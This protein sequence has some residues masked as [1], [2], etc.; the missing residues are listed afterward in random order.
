[1]SAL[2]FD[3]PRCNMSLIYSN[4]HHPNSL[5]DPDSQDPDINFWGSCKYYNVIEMAQVFKD[6]GNQGLS[7]IHVNIRSLAKNLFKLEN[8]LSDINFTP[9]IIAV[10]ETKISVDVI[11]E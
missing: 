7:V 4:P 9:D 10:S 5:H 2:L 6:H 1:M 11:L 3:L 8:F